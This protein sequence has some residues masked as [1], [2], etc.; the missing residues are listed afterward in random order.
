MQKSLVAPLYQLIIGCEISESTFQ[1]YPS[2]HGER[3]S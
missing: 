1:Q 3:H 2:V